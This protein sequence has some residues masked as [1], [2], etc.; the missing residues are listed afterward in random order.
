[1]AAKLIKGEFE[2]GDK[3]HNEAYGYYG[4]VLRME[5]QH[6]TDWVVVLFEGTC[7]SRQVYPDSIKK[8]TERPARVNP[9]C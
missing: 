8:V 1:M 3:V 7:Y 4:T 2:Y 6:R 5:R 9:Y